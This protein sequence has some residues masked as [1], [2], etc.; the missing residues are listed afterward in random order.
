MDEGYLK[1]PDAR[2]LFQD[3]PS[4]PTDL[5]GYTQTAPENRDGKEQ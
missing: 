4:Y 1:T 5:K 3:Y 2:L